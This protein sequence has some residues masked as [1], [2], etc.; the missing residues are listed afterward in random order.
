MSPSGSFTAWHGKQMHIK[1]W[2]KNLKERY[3]LDD[4]VIDGSTIG[5]WFLK[6]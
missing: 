2:Y 5:K 1:V 6:K 4:L 3:Y